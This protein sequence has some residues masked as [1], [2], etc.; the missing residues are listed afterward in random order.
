MAIIARRSFPRYLNSGSSSD[1]ISGS[2]VAYVPALLKGLV[3][4]LLLWAARPLHASFS[5]QFDGLVR[6]LN[7]GGSIT[8]SSPAGVVVD[9]AGN[10]FIADTNNS[11]IVEVNAQGTASVLTI[12]GLTSPSS[13]SSPSAIAID[14]VGN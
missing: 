9:A 3:C 5:L 14:G 4:L 7:T 8:L 6:T 1:L 13:L 2:V 12:S 11:R 10:I